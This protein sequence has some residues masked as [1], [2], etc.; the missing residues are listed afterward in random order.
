MVTDYI[1]INKSKTNKRVLMAESFQAA[2][3]AVKQ[4]WISVFA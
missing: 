3:K 4:N 2:A 1:L